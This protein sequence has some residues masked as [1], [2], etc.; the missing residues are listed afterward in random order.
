MGT[1]FQVT[2]EKR[3]PKKRSIFETVDT[4]MAAVPWTKRRMVLVYKREHGART[5]IQVRTFNRHQLKGCW[6]PAPRFYTVPIECAATLGK[7]IMAAA[8]G[9]RFGPEPDW[10]RD[11]EKQYKALP[12][13]KSRASE[14]AQPAEGDND[15][16]APDAQTLATAWSSQI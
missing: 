13:G 11:F 16:E 10:Y 8:E 2:E 4:L 7:A 14:P 3:Q 15:S 1:I 6:Y 5:Y 9:K 12:R